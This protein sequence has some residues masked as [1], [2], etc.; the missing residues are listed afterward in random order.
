[1]AQS[2]Y[3]KWRPRR[4]EEI[5][6]QEPVVRTLQ[7]AVRT[8]RIS[9]AY[10]FAGPRGTGKTTTARVLAK[11]L[12]CQHPDPAARPCTECQ[13]CRSVQEGRFLDLIEIDAASHTGVDDVRALRETVHFAPTQGRYKVYIIDE[14]HM[15]STAAFNALLK[16]LEEPPDHVVFVLATTEWHKVPATV[17]SRCQVYPFRRIP[18]KDI[19]AYLQRI[20]EAEGI[21]AE[22]DALRAIARQATGSLRDAISLL[23]QLASLGEPITV[24]QVHAL[25]GTAPDEAVH[26]LVE[27]LTEGQGRAALQAVFRAVEGGTDPR[28][29]ARQ[30]VDYL[31]Q[32]MLVQMAAEDLLAT[33]DVWRRRIQEHA[34]RLSMESL[35]RWMR[36]FQKAATGLGTAWYPT[37][38]LEMAVVEALYGVSGETPASPARV[39]VPFPGEAARAA[40]P[41]TAGPARSH[42]APLSPEDEARPLTYDQVMRAW[43][44]VKAW[45]ARYARA[46]GAPEVPGLAEQN[47]VNPVDARGDTVWMNAG[48]ETRQIRYQREPYRSLWQEAWSQVLGRPVRVVWQVGAEPVVEHDENLPQLVRTALQLGGRLQ[49]AIP[50]SPPRTDEPKPTASSS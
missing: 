22:E 9:H 29:L 7:Q 5:V 4:W 39:A 36:L 34:R 47:K 46:K 40:S 16:T 48:N 13:V 6:G 19:V 49:Q 20:V 45:L 8:G 25:L 43:P 41:S 27:A 2:L 37:L 10:L 32:V 31:R 17:R 1:M 3:R 33:S 21:Q 38:P 14:V 30:V 28:V 18:L 44:A 42:G 12:N 15:L 26:A 50:A 11:A 35:V 24:E 23:D